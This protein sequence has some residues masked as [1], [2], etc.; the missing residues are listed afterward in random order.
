MNKSK[1]CFICFTLG[2]LFMGILSY[3]L[4]NDWVMYNTVVDF[5][6]ALG[7]FLES[8]GAVS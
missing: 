1:S 4:S 7:E 3:E 8:R 5:M 2:M 6:K